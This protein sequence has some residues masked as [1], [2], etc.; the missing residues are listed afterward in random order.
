MKNYMMLFSIFVLS[1]CATV[2]RGVNQGFTITSSP[3]GSQ[4]TL[5]TGE[6]CVTPCTLTM[7]RSG[8]FDVTFE[9]EGYKLIV[10]QVV[11]QR[12]DANRGTT[13]GS[14]LYAGAGL[15]VIDM[16]SGALNELTPNPLH[17]DLELDD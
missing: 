13:A 1:A 3:S 14:V 16:L 8:E 15:V 7:S 11:S 9:L 4:V 6:S 2:T 12:A 5:S 17:V 10:T